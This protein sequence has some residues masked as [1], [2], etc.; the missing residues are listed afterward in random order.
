[1]S[2]IP[3]GR[4]AMLKES[5]YESPQTQEIDLLGGISRPFSA[6]FVSFSA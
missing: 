4:Y 2:D 6:S 1:M 3:P 5:V